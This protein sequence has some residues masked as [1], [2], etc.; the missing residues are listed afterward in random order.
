MVRC[1]ALFLLF[2]SS[3]WAESPA[4]TWLTEADKKGQVAHVEARACG[5]AW[6]G[7]IVRV[8]DASGAQVNAPTVGKRV[9]WDMTG[10]G[11]LYKG[12]AYVPAHNRSYAA[13]MEMQG[14][15]M[16]VSGCAGPLC[17]SQMWRRVR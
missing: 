6:C 3:A 2:A 17:L 15:R 16:R 1:L 4:G 11:N 8:Y 5:S 13:R 14:D 12:R 9:F 10:G 7:T